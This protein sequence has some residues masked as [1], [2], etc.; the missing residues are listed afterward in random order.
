MG[1]RLAFLES[2]ALLAR[3]LAGCLRTFLRSS[4]LMLS[5]AALMLVVGAM[6]LVG[7][8]EGDGP[9]ECLTSRGLTAGAFVGTLTGL[10]GVGEARARADVY[11]GCSHKTGD[12]QFSCDY[13]LQC[14]SRSARPT[15]LHGH[16]LDADCVVLIS[17]AHRHGLRTGDRSKG[18][19][20]AHPVCLRVHP[21]G[22]WW[23]SRLPEFLT[24]RSR[25]V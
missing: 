10:L 3:I 19:G 17:V 25:F 5:F 14:G 1:K 2:R 20:S 22:N 6:M 8:R 11:G 13:L 18:S 15:A 21:A 9:C 4:W 16:R 12:W 23:L 24:S 7:R